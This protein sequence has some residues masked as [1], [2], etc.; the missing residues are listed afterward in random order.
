MQGT[1]LD[2]M[3]RNAGIKTVVIVGVSANVAVPNTT[4]DAVNA[5]YQ[6][7]IPATPSAAFP[8]TTPST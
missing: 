2:S 8:L 3:M 4:F 7:V 1:E 5:G 6:V